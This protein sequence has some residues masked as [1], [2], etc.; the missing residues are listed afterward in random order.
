MKLILFSLFLLAGS[1]SAQS[2]S[3]IDNFGRIVLNT[4][5][6]EQIGLPSESKDLLEKKLSQISSNYGMGASD[7]NPRFIITASFNVNT[8]DIIAGPPP[9]IAQNI[10]VT[11]FI[12]DAFE[13]KIFANLIL[14]LKGV[15]NN[16]N[17]SIID[18]LKRINPKI[19]EIESFIQEGK[20]K[21]ISFYNTQCDFIS[22]EAET[23]TKQ[24]NYE[25]AIYKLSLVPEV[26]QDC[27][28]KN[29]D[30]MAAI[31]QQKIDSDCKKILNIA[32]TTWAAAQNHQG[33]EKVGDILTEVNSAANCQSEI[34]KFIKSIDS[35]LKADEKARWQ[36]KIKQYEDKIAKEKE[37]TQL[38]EMQAQREY[39]INKEKLNLE[40]KQAERNFALDKIKISAYRDV[41]IEYLKNRP[42]TIPYNNI[43]WR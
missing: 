38:R 14:S 25:E 20:N 22:K 8:K 35:K 42:K 16:E 10:D 40:G 28:F 7:I 2:Q 39:E 18:A 15:G 36:F 9:M 33:A 13:N 17:K 41:A 11:L 31:Y 4:Y 21:I 27:Y 37:E 30:L 1:V 3:K 43:Y 6:P 19:K 34:N 32:K 23:L 26:C 29:L 24:G 12:G 5:I